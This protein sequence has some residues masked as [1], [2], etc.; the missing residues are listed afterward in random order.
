MAWI[1]QP[2]DP[3]GGLIFAD[4]NFPEM[5]ASKENFTENVCSLSPLTNHHTQRNML[6]NSRWCIILEITDQH[7]FTS[8]I[9]AVLETARNYFMY[10]WRNAAFKGLSSQRAQLAHPNM[11][12]EI[13]VLH[14]HLISTCL[15]RAWLVKGFPL[16]LNNHSGLGK[17]PVLN[18]ICAP[19]A[20]KNSG[21]AFP[22]GEEVNCPSPADVDP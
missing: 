6:S 11:E 16:V 1:K 19:S 17:F 10:G 4:S 7:M 21:T 22:Q 3:S 5:S 15:S 14:L 20:P 8:D 18:A 12:V 2:L 13:K 9:K